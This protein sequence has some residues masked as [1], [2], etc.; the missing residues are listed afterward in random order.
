MHV[1]REISVLMHMHM[2]KVHLRVRAIYSALGTKS[3]S[4]LKWATQ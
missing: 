2:S 1:L 4:K 3:V